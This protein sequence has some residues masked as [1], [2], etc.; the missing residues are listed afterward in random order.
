L[1]VAQT[2]RFGLID[3]VLAFWHQ[4]KN[5]KGDAGNSVIDKQHLHIRDDRRVRDRALREYVDQN[6]PGALLYLAKYID[7]R[8]GELHSK[9][10]A[11]HAQQQQILDQLNAQSE[12]T[13][14]P[15]NRL[16]SK[17]KEYRG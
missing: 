12:P 14:T 2:G 3:E 17:V 11:I 6:G 9:L 15:L 1:A 13:P 8:M 10:D 16:R 7:E 4:R 5:S